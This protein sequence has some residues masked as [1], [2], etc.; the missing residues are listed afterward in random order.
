M[1]KYGPFRML[2]VM[3][4]LH[5]ERKQKEFNVGSRGGRRDSENKEKKYVYSMHMFYA[6]LRLQLCEW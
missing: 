1:T 5:R 3:H 6:A 4:I 2:Q